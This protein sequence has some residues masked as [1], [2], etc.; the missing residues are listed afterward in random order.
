M[1]QSGEEK[2]L[3][4]GNTRKGETGVIHALGRAGSSLLNYHSLRTETKRHRQ[5]DRELHVF[6]PRIRAAAKAQT[7]QKHRFNPANKP[8]F[9]PCNPKRE[10]ERERDERRDFDRS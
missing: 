5:M 7:A 2:C 9:L 6:F 10:R 3:V 4:E 1:G 8:S